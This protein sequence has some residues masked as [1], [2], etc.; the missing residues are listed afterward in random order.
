MKRLLFLLLLLPVSWVT[1]QDAISEVKKQAFGNPYNQAN[2]NFI[3][4]MNEMSS[5]NRVSLLLFDRWM[6][7]QIVGR[8]STMFR[9]D[10][11]NYHIESDK[12]VFFHGGDFYQLFP[13]RIDHVVMGDRTFISMQFIN[14]R[15][16]GRGYFE[17]LEDGE[18]RLLVR[19]EITR[20]VKNDNP[21]GLPAAKEI[22]I[23]QS[24][25]LFYLTATGRRPEPVPRK[26]RELIGIFRRDRAEVADFA[27]EQRLSPK[28]TEDVR[29]LFAFYNQLNAPVN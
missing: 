27:T 4:L 13:E 2:E 25:D 12:I 18:M 22:E 26:R 14:G 17:V 23:R 28:K 16:P 6:P 3:N 24:A 7:M 9:V 5:T 10:S 11:A 19:H 15:E 1:A 21:M 29:R 8:D 20:K